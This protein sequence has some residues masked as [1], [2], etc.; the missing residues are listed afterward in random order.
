MPVAILGVGNHASCGPVRK[1]AIASALTSE[2]ANGSDD[3]AVNIIANVLSDQTAKSFDAAV[4]D[5]Q[6]ENTIALLDC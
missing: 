5:S 4:F 1:L 3:N 2:L 6:P